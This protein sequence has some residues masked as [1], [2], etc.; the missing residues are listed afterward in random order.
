MIQAALKEQAKKLELLGKIIDLDPSAGVSFLSS[1][2]L[3]IVYL[4][5][6]KELFHNGRYSLH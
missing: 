1:F 3:F 4:I 5:S 2:Y 6:F